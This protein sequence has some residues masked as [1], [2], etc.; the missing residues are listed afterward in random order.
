MARGRRGKRR[1]HPSP[2][3]VKGNVCLV[4]MDSVPWVNF[5]KAKVP[6]LRKHSNELRPGYTTATWTRP[7]M[8][9]M[10]LGGMMPCENDKLQAH[11]YIRRIMIP[12]VPVQA[13][14]AGYFTA[15]VITIPRIL[16]GN[17]FHKFEVLPAYRETATLALQKVKNFHLKQKQPFFLLFHLS[18]THMAFNCE[19]K[20]PTKYRKGVD[21]YNT[22][23]RDWSDK[24]L[25]YLRGEQIKCI[26]FLDSK[27]KELYKM[28][29]PTN[30]IVTADHGD[31]FGENHR[32]GHG[33]WN[34]ENLFKVPFCY[35]KPKG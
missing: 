27:I 8:L 2:F 15:G 23:K 19:G 7:S 29:P 5:E 28:L 18:E 30:M 17:G 22:D 16:D 20:P 35:I 1:K 33:Y 12:T 14:L 10:V 21:A 24:Y 26:E 4:V 9:S 31:L 11:D 32:F 3:N 34:H 6:F 13:Q 25:N